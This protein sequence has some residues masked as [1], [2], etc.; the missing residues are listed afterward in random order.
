MNTDIC[1]SIN[2]DESNNKSDNND[3]VIY[4]STI[5]NV[6][7][8]HDIIGHQH[9]N[10]LTC[11]YYHIHLFIMLL[12]KMLFVYQ[13]RIV[14]IANLIL[15]IAFFLF[16]Y[17]Q[18]HINILYFNLTTSIINLCDYLLAYQQHLV[19]VHYYFL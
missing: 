10:I 15:V 6:D 7:M 14:F 1:N 13:L 8:L 17:I 12:F 2:D 16:H 9:I 3:N 19:F 11:N 4:K 18:I 5:Q